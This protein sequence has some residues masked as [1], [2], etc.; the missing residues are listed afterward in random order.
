[1][2]TF[3]VIYRIG[4]TERFTWHR[5]VPQRKKADAEAMRADLERAGFKALVHETAKLDSIGMPETF[6]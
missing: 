1:M 5:C 2:K 3:T 6:E 4:G